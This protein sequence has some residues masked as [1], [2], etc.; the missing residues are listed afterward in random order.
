[1]RRQYITF[2]RRKIISSIVSYSESTF[3]IHYAIFT[4]F[5]CNI[6]ASRVLLAAK[7]IL[8]LSRPYPKYGALRVL[9]DKNNDFL[10]ALPKQSRIDGRSRSESMKRA[11]ELQDFIAKHTVQK[12]ACSANQVLLCNLTANRHLALTLPAIPVKL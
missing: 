11:G 6:R 12:S 2:L 8:S 7:A 9:A 5:T 1:M 10:K 4:V 3:N